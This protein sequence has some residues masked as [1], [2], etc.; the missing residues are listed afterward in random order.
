MNKYLKSGVCGL[1]Y[2]MVQK[3]EKEQGLF[4]IFNKTDK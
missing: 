2:F 4:L 3:R 1:L